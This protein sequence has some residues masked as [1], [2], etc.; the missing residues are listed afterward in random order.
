MC[1]NETQSQSGVTFIT[2]VINPTLSFLLLIAP[3]CDCVPW[4][5]RPISHDIGILASKDPVAL[6]K[7]CYDLDV[8]A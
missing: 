1:R 5:G 3:L 6:D 7:A 4:S 8:H 2:N